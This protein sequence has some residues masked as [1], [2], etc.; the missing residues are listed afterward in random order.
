MGGYAGS[1]ITEVVGVEGGGGRKLNSGVS[2]LQLMRP[3]AEA[4]GTF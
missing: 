1:A 4:Q 2:T 3:K